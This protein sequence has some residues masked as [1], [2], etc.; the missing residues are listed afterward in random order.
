MPENVRQESSRL[1]ADGFVH[2]R[3]DPALFDDEAGKR[4]VDSWNNLRQDT[5]MADGGTYRLRRYSEF[6]CA[7][8]AP[9]VT[10]LPHV[11]YAQ[12]KEINHLN[13]GIERSFEPFEAEVA[14]SP[15]LESVFR[16]CA[17]AM[18]GAGADGAYKVQTF[19]NRILARHGEKG[20]PAPEGMHRDGVDFVLTLLVE[21]NSV[22]G[23]TS[24]VYD[25][26]S[27]ECRAEVQLAEPGE[28]LFAD[29]VRMLHDVTAVTPASDD[30]DGHRDVLIAMF[31]RI[32]GTG[33]ENR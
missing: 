29:D 5:Y 27:R 6:R 16:W 18:S 24:S 7:A 3:L 13:G 2:G 1:V 14:A 15:V 17:D 20:E 21:R 22:D 10:L 12:S 25:A 28:F 32:G 23:G 33:E 31:T 9:G 4:F 19:Q 30:R 11:P 8:D 26:D